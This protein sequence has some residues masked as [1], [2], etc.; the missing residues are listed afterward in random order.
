MARRPRVGAGRDQ[1]WAHPSG[2]TMGAGWA[3]G[4]PARRLRAVAPGARCGPHR[5]VSASRARSR[6]AFRGERRGAGRSTARRQDRMGRALERVRGGDPSGAEDRA[7]RVGA[8]PA[9]SVL[10]GG[11]G[12][13]SRALLRGAGDRVP[14][15][16][17]DRRRT[18]HP[19]AAR[20]PGAR[21]DGVLGSACPPT[22]W[23][24]PGRWPSR[25]RSSSSRAPGGSS[26]RSTVSARAT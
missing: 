14:R 11:A 16:Q 15:L 22:R 20:A 5:A 6:R 8:E 24:S 7:D 17:P 9:E 19:E 21:A 25:P 23:S 3:A 4:A 26:T 10:S 12:G 18:A 2:R 1:G 13:R